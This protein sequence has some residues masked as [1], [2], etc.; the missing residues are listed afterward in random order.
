MN[1]L[2]DLAALQVMDTVREELESEGETILTKRDLAWLSPAFIALNAKYF[3]ENPKA[4][5][6]A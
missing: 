1:N 6:S 5:S 3:S 4:A 2:S